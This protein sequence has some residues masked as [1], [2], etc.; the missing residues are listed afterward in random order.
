LPINKVKHLMITWIFRSLTNLIIT[1]G[2]V[3]LFYHQ[4]LC[5]LM[6]KIALNNGK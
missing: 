5:V 3:L 6:K 4:C 1:V 2:K